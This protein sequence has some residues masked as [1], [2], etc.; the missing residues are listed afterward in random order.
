MIQG[1]M[2][3]GVD[4]TPGP[5]SY[6][7]F[8][9]VEVSGAGQG[10]EESYA[11]DGISIEKGH[12]ITVEHCYIHDNG[13]DGIDLNSRDRRGRVPGIVVR[14]NVVARNHLNGI[15][16]WSG[17]RMA[18]NLVWGQGDTP[19][20]MGPYRGRAEI[21]YNTVAYNMWAR[22]FGERNYAAA[23][24]YP[25]EGIAKPRLDLVMHHNIFAFNGGPAQGE[26]TGVYLGPG[27]RLRAEHHNVFYSAPENEI[28]A[29]FLGREREFSRRDLNQGVWAKATGQGKGDLSVNPRFTSG[30]PRVDLHLQPGSPAVGRGAYALP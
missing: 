27:V 17:G 26:P 6:L 30:W 20:W 16:L 7:T 9:R 21:I 19:I 15:K 8:R 4:G 22:E 2:Y 24:G 28:L 1:P 11:A 5:C 29:L 12:Y 23:L 18:G 14:R 25:E 13:G 10:G 3:A